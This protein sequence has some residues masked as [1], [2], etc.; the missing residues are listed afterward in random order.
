MPL[1]GAVS[2]LGVVW[3][4][5]RKWGKIAG[6]GTDEHAAGGQKL[7]EIRRLVQLGAGSNPKD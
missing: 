1:P 5:L 7:A 3:L 6:G 4:A 2:S